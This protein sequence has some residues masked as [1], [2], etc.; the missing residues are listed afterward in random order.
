MK[1]KIEALQK[2]LDGSLVNPDEDGTFGTDGSHEA[3][4]EEFERAFDKAVRVAEK[5]IA[6]L[7]SLQ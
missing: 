6:L 4:M 5:A 2:E 3:L 1:E 7:R